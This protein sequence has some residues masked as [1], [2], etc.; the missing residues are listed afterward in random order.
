[1][2]NR[3]A[4]FGFSLAALLAL[5]EVFLFLAITEV[6]PQ[7]FPPYMPDGV[8][9]TLIFLPFAAVW[10]YTVCSIGGRTQSV[11]DVLL[12]GLGGLGA[13]VVATSTAYIPF[14]GYRLMRGIIILLGIAAIGLAIYGY[15]QA[16][17]CIPCGIACMNTCYFAVNFF[18]IGMASGSGYGSATTA[19]WTMIFLP[20]LIGLIITD[21]VDAAR[22]APERPV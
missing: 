14:L 12:V 4:V 18:L 19:I 21:A 11:K 13:A 16:G 3:F 9:L 1:M 5:E 8:V 2:K 15:R 22:E 17:E 20:V 10:L 6:A 7:Y